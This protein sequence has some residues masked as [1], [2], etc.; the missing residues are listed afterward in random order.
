MSADLLALAAAHP[1]TV[2]SARLVWEAA[3]TVAD[4]VL[5]GPGPLGERFL[6]P[7]TGG[8]FRGGPGYETLY[9]RVLPG[10]ADRQLLRSDGVKELDATYEMRV[11]D[12]TVIGV[13][14]R[15]I[16]DERES[17]R[18]ARSVVQVQAP[19]GTWE[20]LNR[21]LFVGTLVSLRPQAVAVLVRVFELG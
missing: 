21:R 11:H 7:I 2:P 3:V 8:V 10:G 15:V 16:L 6:V 12:G 14:N 1:V 17:P 4:R 13:R 9:G 18:Y 19:A 20:A 5:V